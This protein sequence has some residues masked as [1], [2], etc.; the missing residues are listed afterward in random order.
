MMSNK[1]YAIVAG[2]GPGTGRSVAVRFS[3]AYP[4][5]LFSR[6]PESYNDV[7]AEINTAGGKAIGITTD[8]TDEASVAS[9]FETIEKELPGLKLAAA[10]YNVR[11]S[12][13]PSQKPFLE[14]T[15][16]QLDSSLN[17]SVYVVSQD[18]C[19]L[20]CVSDRTCLAAVFS[21]LLKWYCLCYLSP[22]IALPIHRP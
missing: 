16:E 13:R 21:S 6:H 1:F 19:C 2:V 8:S 9:A 12:G 14:L 18:S 10:V 7:V 15:L 4:V 5:V 3:K 20:C 11:Q 17:G 22:W